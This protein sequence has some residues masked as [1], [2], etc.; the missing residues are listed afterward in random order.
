ME[1]ITAGHSLDS[2]IPG[3]NDITAQYTSLQLVIVLQ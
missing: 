2:L 3:Q 1:E